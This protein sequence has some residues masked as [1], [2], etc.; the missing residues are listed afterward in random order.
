MKSVKTLQSFSACR[1]L[2][3]LNVY[4][5]EFQLWQIWD[6]KGLIKLMQDLLH[7]FVDF[8]L[9]LLKT[10]RG[11]SRKKADKLRWRLIKRNQTEQRWQSGNK[12]SS[13]FLVSLMTETFGCAGSLLRLCGHFRLFKIKHLTIWTLSSLRSDLI[14]LEQSALHVPVC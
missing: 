13:L 8:L 2:S 3:K 14:G 10:F 1:I 11:N 5:F 6:A 7:P 4:T 9:Y 12:N